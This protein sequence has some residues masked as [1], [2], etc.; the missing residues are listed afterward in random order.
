[1]LRSGD[2]QKPLVSEAARVGLAKEGRGIDVSELA[3]NT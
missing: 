1:M 2:T 3:A